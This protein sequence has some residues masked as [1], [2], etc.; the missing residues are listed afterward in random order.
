MR[1]TYTA[2]LILLDAIILF[3][4]EY[5]YEAPHYEMLM[6]LTFLKIIRGENYKLM[7]SQLSY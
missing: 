2:H 4:E 1:A 3:D 5:N 7:T 6:T